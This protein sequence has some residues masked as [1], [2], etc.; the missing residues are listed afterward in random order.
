M[1][2]AQDLADTRYAVTGQRTVRVDRGTAQKGPPEA[3]L[4]SQGANR[5]MTIHPCD[6][7]KGRNVAVTLK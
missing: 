1:Y 5:T 3:V 7:D 4:Q 2:A 6:T